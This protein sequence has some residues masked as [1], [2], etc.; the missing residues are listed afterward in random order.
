VWL[1]E[2]KDGVVN[3]P[4]DTIRARP[5]EVAAQR[6]GDDIVTEADVVMDR[7]FTVAA[8]PERAWP[9]LLQLGKYRAGWYLPRSL[10]RFIPRSRRP[11]RTVVAIWR[12]LEVG[13]VLP[14]YGGK[15]ESFQVAI[16]QPPS[17]LVYRS[18]RGQMQVSWS[19]TL[20][21]L[22]G[23][24]VDARPLTRIHLRLRLGSVRRKWLVKT[25][26]ELLDILT[27]AVMAAGLRERLTDQTSTCGK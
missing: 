25:A 4:F 19:I 24:R 3:G 22:P 5:D 15:N 21:V 10:E 2:G 1:P 9:W 26:G 8:P 20:S 14:D 11:A 27:I 6:L 13:D 17:A 16:L 23:A 7:A 18:Q 12:H